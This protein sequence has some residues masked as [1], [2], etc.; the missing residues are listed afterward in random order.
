MNATA[1]QHYRAERQ[2]EADGAHQITAGDMTALGGTHSSK[3]RLEVVRYHGT[4][5]VRRYSIET[6]QA[7][8]PY[9]TGDVSADELEAAYQAALRDEQ[10]TEE[11]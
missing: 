3:R 9:R 5:H 8:W 4:P 7:E 11:A 10:T 2:A 6:E 1:Q